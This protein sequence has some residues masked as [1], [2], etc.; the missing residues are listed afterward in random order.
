MFEL[1]SSNEIGSENFL[2]GIKKA[3]LRLGKAAE[4]V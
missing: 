1:E 3:T 4:E 2:D